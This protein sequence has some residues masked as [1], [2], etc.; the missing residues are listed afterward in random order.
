MK[1][2]CRH[3][4]FFWCSLVPKRISLLRY[5]KIRNTIGK[6]KY[7]EEQTVQI[8]DITEHILS[9]PFSILTLQF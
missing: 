7:S 8:I 2:D 4:F 1:P 3:F 9:D 5:P 6:L